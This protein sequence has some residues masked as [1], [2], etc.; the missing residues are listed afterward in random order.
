[1]SS[2]SCPIQGCNPGLPRTRVTPRALLTPQSTLN[3]LHYVLY[4]VHSTLQNLHYSKLYT[5][6]CTVNTERRTLNTE[7][8]ILKITHCTG[9]IWQIAVHSKG[10]CWPG[11]VLHASSHCV[12]YMVQS[13]SSTIKIHSIHTKHT[14]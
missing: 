12:H 5:A 9:H 14:K 8:R 13:T 3:T 11:H 10:C 4:T 2:V 1:M 7:H 6:H